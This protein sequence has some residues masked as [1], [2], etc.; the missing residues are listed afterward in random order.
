MKK[1]VT[2]CKKWPSWGRLYALKCVTPVWGSDELMLLMRWCCL[3]RWCA[4][5]A[6]AA[7]A[8]ML[9]MC[10]CAHT[11]DAAYAA[12]MLMLLIRWCCWY[13]DA[14]MRWCCWCANAADALMLLMLLMRWCCWCTD[15]ILVISVSF[16][17]IVTKV[18]IAFMFKLLSRTGVC[19]KSGL[20]LYRHKP[21]WL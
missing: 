2:I 11:A 5:A 17:I 18:I 7:G 15:V 12:D 21:L 3:C 19:S 13:T 16:V 9:L 6:Y 8:L 14:L 10:W 4:D 1:T 20:L